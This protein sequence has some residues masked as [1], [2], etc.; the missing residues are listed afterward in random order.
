M[1]GRM[2]GATRRLQGGGLGCRGACKADFCDCRHI[3]E[4][5]ASLGSVHP[6]RWSPENPEKENY[7]DDDLQEDLHRCAH[8]RCAR[9]GVACYHRQRSRPSRQALWLT[10]RPPPTSRA[11]PPPWSPSP[12]P[13]RPLASWRGVLRRRGSLELLAVD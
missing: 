11:P 8:G 10:P 4:V 13:V 1:P 6:G 3:G 9:S 12:P 7:N 5:A 2:K